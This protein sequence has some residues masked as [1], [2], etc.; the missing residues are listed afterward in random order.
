MKELEVEYEALQRKVWKASPENTKASD[1]LR[2]R[3]I[4]QAIGTPHALEIRRKILS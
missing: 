3:E 4:K 1:A 2:L